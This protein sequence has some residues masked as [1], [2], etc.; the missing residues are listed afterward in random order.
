MIITSKSRKRKRD[1]NTDA[2]IERNEGRDRWT[3]R[4]KVGKWHKNLKLGCRVVFRYHMA[5][6]FFQATLTIPHF[7]LSLSHA[8]G[9]RYSECTHTYTLLT[10][11][12]T[13]LGISLAHTRTLSSSIYP[14]H[15]LLTSLLST[16]IHPLYSLTPSLHF[17][18]LACPTSSLSLSQVYLPTF[19]IT[20]ILTYH[21]SASLSLCLFLS[22]CA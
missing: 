14:T 11:T 9:H 20:P 16:S 3:E 17:S 4:E 21:L 10:N 7:A 1:T 8:D 2:K 12:H 5:D 13:L 15:Q 22:L 18:P 6:N 19:T